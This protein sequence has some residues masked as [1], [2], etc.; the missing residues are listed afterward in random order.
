MYSL[1]MFNKPWIALIVFSSPV[2]KLTIVMG[3]DCSKSM[4][5]LVR[6]CV[7]PGKAELSWN[8]SCSGLSVL[9]SI[10][11]VN[12]KMIAPALRSSV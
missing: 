1:L 5:T 8:L 9:P 3:E 2:V 10:T 12:V 11:S 4:I 6:V 7:R